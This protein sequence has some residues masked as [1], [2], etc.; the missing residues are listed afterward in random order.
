MMIKRFNDNFTPD[1]LKKLFPEDRANRFFDAL[2]GDPA[3]G[4]Y[5][6]N[7]EFKNT[8]KIGLSLRYTLSSDPENA[9][10]AI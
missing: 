1:V 2:F 9:S 3:E 7:L 5:D 8:V 10:I 4:A 6:I